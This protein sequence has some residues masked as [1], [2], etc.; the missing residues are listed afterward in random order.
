MARRGTIGSGETLVSGGIGGI[1]GGGI[2]SNLVGGIFTTKST[3]T[4]ELQ[5]V[6]D[7]VGTEEDDCEGV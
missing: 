4:P 7:Q 2:V 3:L 5:L 6:L 1:G